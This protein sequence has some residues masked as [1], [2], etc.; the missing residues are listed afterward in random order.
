[1]RRK[2]FVMTAAAGLAAWATGLSE[3]RGSSRTAEAMDARE[4][5]G[6]ACGLDSYAQTPPEADYLAR[7]LRRFFEFTDAGNAKAREI[8]RLGLTEYPGSV[9][10]QTRLAWTYLQDL[11]YLRSKDPAGDIDRAYT[12]VKDA[13]GANA[14]LGDAA[15]SNHWAMV[16]LALLHDHDAA[17][18]LAE[19]R[20][21]HRIFPD[22]ARANSNLSFWVAAAGDVNLAVEWAEAALRC[23]PPGPKWI[24]GNLGSV[25]YF[26]GR[27]QEA[28]DKILPAKDDFPD[29]V[30]NIYVAL[31]RL[32][33]ARA[34]VAEWRKADPSVTVTKMAILTPLVEPLMR[35]YLDGLRKVGLPEA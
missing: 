15:W 26:A 32:S 6:P 35:R 23:E 34:T 28:L 7:G 13:S 17:R 25:Y 14:V 16:S 19:A 9:W 24:T 12:L 2:T 30:T 11:F 10:L 4:H 8:W 22:D 33:D 3:S 20:F 29:F 21:V 1:M 31:G 5:S 27:H 18:A